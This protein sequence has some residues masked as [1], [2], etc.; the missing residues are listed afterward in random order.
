MLIFFPLNLRIS[1]THLDSPDIVEMGLAQMLS[2]TFD[3]NLL[4]EMDVLVLYLL[5][6]KAK[7]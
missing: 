4:D 1:I 3:H 6:E 2:Q 7:L 5:S